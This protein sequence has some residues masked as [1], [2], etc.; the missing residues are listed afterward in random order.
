MKQENTEDNVILD[1]T[2]P[3]SDNKQGIKLPSFS[4]NSFIRNS[5]ASGIA[6]GLILGIVKYLYQESSITSY[7]IL[8]ASQAM[9]TL[10]MFS[11]LLYKGIYVLD[12]E[13]E[14]RNPVIVRGFISFFG[15][16]LFYQSLQYLDSVTVGVTI[17]VSSELIAHF[18]FLKQER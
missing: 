10:L 17:L 16:V 8:Y 13:T 15:I 7:E 3:R 12:V 4:K 18:F 2:I 11:H 14:L 5:L 1:P 6:S 9:C